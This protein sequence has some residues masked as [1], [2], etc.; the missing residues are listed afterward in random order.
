MEVHRAAASV[1]ATK[2]LVST[3]TSWTKGKMPNTKGPYGRGSSLKAAHS[4]H[5]SALLMVS[6]LVGAVQLERSKCCL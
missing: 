6:V 4:V 2:Q 1:K 3:N 5:S